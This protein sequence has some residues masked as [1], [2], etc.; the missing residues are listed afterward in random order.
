MSGKKIRPDCTHSLL[1]CL[2]RRSTSRY[3]TRSDSL[4]SVTLPTQ[5]VHFSSPYPLTQST[6][7]HFTHSDS[8]LSVTL[9]TQSTSVTLPKQ[10]VH[11]PSLYPLKQSTSVTLPTQTV[12]FLSPYLLRQS[13]SVTLPTQTVHFPSLYPLSLL[14]SPYLLRQS[15][16]CHLTH[17]DS[18]LPFTLPA[19]LPKCCFYFVSSLTSPE[20]EQVM[21]GNFGAVNVSCFSLVINIASL[22]NSPTVYFLVTSLVFKSLTV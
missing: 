4:L 21:L 5:T 3:L 11:F 14:P 9:P 17:S 1:C 12:Y 20:E 7:C 19:W 22:N 18:P 6:S 10:T 8:P 2:I 15:T 13:T 16:S